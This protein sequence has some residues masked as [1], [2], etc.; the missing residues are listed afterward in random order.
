MDLDVDGNTA[1][2]TA[3]SSGLGKASAEVLARE[4]ANIVVN[5]RDQE[6]LDSTVSELSETATGQVVGHQGDITD[7]EDIEQLVSRTV[8]EF[9]GLDH[10][11]TS[12]GGPPSGPFLEIPEEEWYKEF[13]LLVMSV[14]R[15]VHEAVEHLQ[16][17]GGGTIVNIT[18]ISVK[19]AIDALVLSNS[20]RMAVIGL[21]KTLSK[22]LA[23]EIRV[24]SVLPNRIETPRVEDLLQGQVDAGH[25][26]SY[27]Q[28]YDQWIQDIPVQ[29]LGEPEE[30]GNLVAF[31]C[32]ERSGF[33][34]GAAIPID[35]GEFRSNL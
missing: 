19:E 17:D 6:Q 1:L 21:E 15:L 32:S 31:L 5:G 30:L 26:E 23:P 2:I 22:E 35:G 10:L 20:V 27:E 13:D 7:P 3:S 25:Y 29:R 12:A 8:D 18:S 9:G 28:G 4:G 14:V 33:I 16:A 11:V 24:N 34:N